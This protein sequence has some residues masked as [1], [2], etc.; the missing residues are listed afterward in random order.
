MGWGGALRGDPDPFGFA[1][2]LTAGK[3]P[4]PTRGL[5]RP[6]AS[7]APGAGR[8]GAP[9]GAGRGA[10]GGA[11]PGSGFVRQPHARGR[12]PTRGP[13]RPAAGA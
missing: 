6:P 13:G 3:T 7:E 9:A 8:R 10:P 4:T 1:L 11:A 2:A 5:G 12:K